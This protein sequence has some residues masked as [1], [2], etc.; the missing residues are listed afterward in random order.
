MQE[1]DILAAF[2]TT[3]PPQ[4]FV[5]P[6]FLAGTVGAL[7]APGS[8]G[9]SMFALQL[10]SAVASPVAAANTLGLTIERHGRVVYLNLEEPPGEIERRLFSLGKCFD[11]ATH[12]AI[13]ENLLLSAR[14]G[15][16]TDIMSDKF[17]S[18]LIKEAKG[19]RLIILDTLS[20]AHGF[21]ENDNGAMSRVVARMELIA[22]ETGSALLYLHHTSKAAALD[23]KGAMAQAARGASALID[24]ARWCG[25]LMKMTEEEAEKFS[26][27]SPR[28][29][30]IG[31]E[32]RGYF[33]RYEIGKQN[34]GE[35]QGGRWY[36]RTDGGILKPI[37]LWQTNGKKHGGR[38]EF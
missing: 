23:G 16:P 4:D 3:P 10:A 33:V 28:S 20:R 8:T 1:I 11:A 21:D 36:Q 14:M 27:D 12:P 5:I 37:E 9:K 13:A 6:G 7:I 34:Y 19:A 26:E 17:M 15:V 32:R 18:E 25:N 29:A 35:V 22:R 38:D 2:G 24:N 31:A 30:P